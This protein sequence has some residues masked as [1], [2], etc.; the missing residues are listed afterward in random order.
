MLDVVIVGAGL[1]GSIAAE[2]LRLDGHTVMCID[3]REPFAGSRPAACLM[4]PSW[5]AGLGKENTDAS[6]EL[7]DKLY[8]VHTLSFRV[9][10]LA[11]ANVYWCDPADILHETVFE[12]RVVAVDPHGTGWAVQTHTGTRIEARRVIL[13]AG[14]WTGA[15]RPVEGLV[16]RAGVAF[17]WGGF[18]LPEGFIR[19]WAPYRQTVGFNISPQEVWV[20]DGSAI[21]PENWTDERQRMS[22]MRCAEAIDRPDYNDLSTGAARP[23]YG[24]R[25]YVPG[26]KPSYLREVAPGLWINTGGAKNGTVAAGWAASVLRSA[27]K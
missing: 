6:L 20:G 2:A 8:G 24:I 26:A 16:G 12:A 21:K 19:P 7:L 14:V 15:L 25:P 9:G 1:F 13:A 11:K 3:K 4:K 10:G 5:F 23:L 22:F 17:R 27:L 18:Q